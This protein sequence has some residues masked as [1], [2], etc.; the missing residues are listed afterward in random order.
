[1]AAQRSG[2]VDAEVVLVILAL[3]RVRGARVEELLR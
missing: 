1:M 3:S 2:A